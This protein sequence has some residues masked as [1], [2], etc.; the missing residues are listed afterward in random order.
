MIGN[1]FLNNERVH[2]SRLILAVNVMHCILLLVLHFP[3]LLQFLILLSKIKS[4]LTRFRSSCFVF[5]L[6]SLFQCAWNGAGYYI[7]VFSKRYIEKLEK[8]EAESSITRN[9]SM[10]KKSAD[11]ENLQSDSI[12]CI[13]RTSSEDHNGN[14]S[15][16]TGYTDLD[17]SNS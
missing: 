9:D 7:N 12:K 8:L 14:L 13:D 1:L 5:I 3:F 15:E 10:A 2:Q 4:I 6:A 17:R 16:D 11:N